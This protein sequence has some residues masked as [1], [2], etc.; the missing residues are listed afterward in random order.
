MA[1]LD[2]IA[3]HMIEPLP[4]PNPDYLAALIILY[5]TLIEISLS[6][7]TSTLRFIACNTHM[8]ESYQ[9]FIKFDILRHLLV[10]FFKIIY[11]VHW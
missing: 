6:Q 5:S 4:N 1:L 10:E 3:L 11:T 2:L 8:L 7:A 9:I